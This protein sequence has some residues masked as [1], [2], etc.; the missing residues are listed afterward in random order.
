MTVGKQ[1]RNGHETFAHGRHTYRLCVEN[2]MDYCFLSCMEIGAVRCGNDT[3]DTNINM[4]DMATIQ[5]AHGY[6]CN[7][8]F[9]L[10]IPQS[11]SILE[12]M[13]CHVN[14][15]HFKPKL[16]FDRGVLNR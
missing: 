10:A 8:C 7:P 15:Q 6:S 16:R 12:V 9:F 4:A 14:I 1:G 2:N 3:G 5:I 11:N 13:S